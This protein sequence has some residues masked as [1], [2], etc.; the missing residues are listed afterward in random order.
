MAKQ[1]Q[2]EYET[3]FILS[4]SADGEARE[5]AVERVEGIIENSGGHILKLDEWG[6]RE[7]A[8]QISDKDGNRHDSGLYHYCRY[9]APSD[10]IAELERN[11]RIL[12]QVLKYL[13]VKLDED[14]D[15]EERVSQGVEDEDVD[16]AP[17]EEEEE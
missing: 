3:I 13:T 5:R 1:L 17:S 16:V 4:P 14:I 11:L 15:P 6:S 2:R 12:D 9:I 8:Y 7:L 10:S